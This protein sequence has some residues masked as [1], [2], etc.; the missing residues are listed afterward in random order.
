MCWGS[1]GPVDLYGTVIQQRSY[2]MSWI[3]SYTHSPVSEKDPCDFSVNI[4]K[5]V[6]IPN[7]FYDISDPFR[8][9]TI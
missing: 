8:K 6:I 7:L 2:S 3:P 9:L 4:R 1:E 5:N